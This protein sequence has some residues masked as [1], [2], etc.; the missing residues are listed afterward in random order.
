MAEMI[1]P[2]PS[3]YRLFR[4]NGAGRID[5]VAQAIEA[6]NDAEAVR[7][8]QARSEGRMAELWLGARRI[9]MLNGSVRTER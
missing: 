1:R 3:S 7:Q 6:E 5:S 8:A 4:T 9:A 2:S